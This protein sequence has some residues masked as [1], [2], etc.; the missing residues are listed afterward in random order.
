VHISLPQ[1]LISA[2]QTTST[3]AATSA[4]NPGQDLTSTFLKLLATQLK[5]QS[6]INPLDPNQFV[7]Q[8]TQF[9]SLGELTQIQQLLQKLVNNTTPKTTTM[10]NASAN[11]IS[12][13]SP[14]S[15]SL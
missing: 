11:S 10:S 4:S 3:A 14:K 15:S 5:A 2:A 8:L 12:A 6:P 9:S 1:A 13:P 7:S